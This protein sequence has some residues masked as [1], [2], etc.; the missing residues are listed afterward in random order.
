MHEQRLHMFE[1]IKEG[2][3]NARW[4]SSFDSIKRL[5]Y[6]KRVQ[7]SVVKSVDI[8]DIP[9]TLIT[10]DPEQARKFYYSHSGEVV[11][12]CLHHH[13]VQIKNRGYMI[14]T[15][16]LLESELSKLDDSLALAPCIFQRNIEKQSERLI[17]VVREQVFSARLIL[18]SKRSLDED[19]H[20]SK[21]DND[22]DIE[23][24]ELSQDVKN[25]MVKLM[26]AFGLEYCSLDFIEDKDDRPIFLEVNSTDDWAFIEDT[27]GLPITETISK[28][29]ME[30]KTTI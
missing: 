14:Y 16:R 10:N 18:K 19:I 17:T 27:T 7:L 11:V 6:N 8:F 2:T 22:I 5:R 9:E 21:H 3:S 28:I 15:H 30:E 20:L 26:K 1:I 4:L 12:K 13:L 25:R 24:F 23:P 29:I